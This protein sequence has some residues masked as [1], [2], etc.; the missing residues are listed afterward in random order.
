MGIFNKTSELKKKY[1]VD[2]AV[3]C[4]GN[5][6]EVKK[7]TSKETGK[8]HAIKSIDKAKVEDMEDISR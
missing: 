1:D 4:S 8:T 2:N 5:F 7:C 3:L 6:T